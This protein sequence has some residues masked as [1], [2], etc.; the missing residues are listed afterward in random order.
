MMFV[1]DFRSRRSGTSGEFEKANF[2]TRFL[3]L[4]RLKGRFQAVGQAGFN[5]YSPTVRGRRHAGAHLPLVVY[6]YDDA[7]LA[8]LLPDVAAQKLNLKLQILKPV[9]FTS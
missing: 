8:K 4:D 3:L 1:L 6:V 2:E 9:F 5:L 7:V